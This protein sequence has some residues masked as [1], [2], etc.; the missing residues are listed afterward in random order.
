MGTMDHP[1]LQFLSAVFWSYYTGVGG[2]VSLAIELSRKRTN[3]LHWWWIFAVAGVLLASYQA[4]D[5]QRL[6]RIAAE[7]TVVTLQGQIDQLTK[8]IIVGEVRRMFSAIE[9][10]GTIQQ[11]LEV[12][13]ENRGASSVLINW[14]LSIHGDSLDISAINCVMPETLTMNSSIGLTGRINRVH[15]LQ[16]ITTKKID[17]GDSRIGWLVFTLPQFDY[18]HLK[19]GTRFEITC[20]DAFGNVWAIEKILEKGS[21]PLTQNQALMYDPGSEQL[22]LL[23]SPSA[24]PTPHSHRLRRP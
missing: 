3:H 7:G 17:R 22:F 24:S 21:F 6:A 12:Y 10:D 19:K 2:I 14:N 5:Q 8:P 4:W 11:V 15:M 16:E 9:P 13:V 20:V 18:K 1:T 23:P